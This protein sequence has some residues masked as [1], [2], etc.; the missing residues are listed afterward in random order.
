MKDFMA[1]IGIVTIIL[2]IMFFLSWVLYEYA[3][4]KCVEK[5]GYKTIGGKAFICVDRYG[6][7]VP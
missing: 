4:N 1:T 3:H 2:A 7:I 5:W 6:R